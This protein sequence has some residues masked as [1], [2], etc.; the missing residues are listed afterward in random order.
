M[1]VVSAAQYEFAATRHPFAYQP[2]ERKKGAIGAANST[3][4]DVKKPL[5]QCCRNSVECPV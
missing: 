3:T 2:N 5:L 4:V 1:E